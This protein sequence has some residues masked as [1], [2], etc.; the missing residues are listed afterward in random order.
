MPPA[1]LNY[2]YNSTFSISL[3]VITDNVITGITISLIIG[4]ISVLFVFRS[5]SK[6]FYTPLILLSLLTIVSFIAPSFQYFFMLFTS[7]L[8]FLLSVPYLD[9]YIPV[10]LRIAEILFQLLYVSGIVLYFEKIYNGF[11]FQTGVIYS[12]CILYIIIS[13]Y[14]FFE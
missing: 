1:Q 5:F 7:S 13:K 9:N 11:F 4:L 2:N 10:R 3:L 14:L 6:H 8:I 12:F